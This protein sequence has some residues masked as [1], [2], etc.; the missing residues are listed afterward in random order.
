M[1]LNAHITGQQRKFSAREFKVCGTGPKS[2]LESSSS[3]IQQGNCTMICSSTVFELN[4]ANAS[5]LNLIFNETFCIHFHAAYQFLARTEKVRS[6][7]VN[8][9]NTK[10]KRPKQFK[11]KSKRA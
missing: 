1:V 7:L 5:L 4:L 10:N 9:H 8:G 6:N 11:I 3:T 2:V